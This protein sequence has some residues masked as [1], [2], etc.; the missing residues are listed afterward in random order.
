[1]QLDLH[2]C[3]CGMPSNNEYS[4]AGGNWARYDDMLKAFASANDDVE[5]LVCRCLSTNMALFCKTA[6]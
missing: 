3:T 2:T 4:L 5:V 1:M 6:L